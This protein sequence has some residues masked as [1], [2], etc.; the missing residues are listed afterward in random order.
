MNNLKKIDK[1]SCL[2]ELCPLYDEKKILNAPHFVDLSMTMS[3]KNMHYES[4]ARQRG[5]CG[6]TMHSNIMQMWRVS[7]S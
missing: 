7:V 5:G 2:G 6:I 4:V 1:Y 3:H